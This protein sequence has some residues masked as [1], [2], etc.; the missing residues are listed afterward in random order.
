MNAVF[1]SLLGFIVL[2][3]G[4]AAWAAR[5]IRSESDFLVAGRSLGPWMAT[6]TVF[7]TWFGAETCIGAAGEAYAGGLA[8]VRVDPFGYAIG[9][10]LMGLLL[11]AALWR[12]QLLTL[13]DLFRQRWGGGVERLA[14]LIMIPTSLLWAAAQ[15]RALGQVM[16]MTGLEEVTLGIQVAALVVILYT[17]VGGLWADALSDLVQGLVLIAGLLGLAVMVWLLPEGAAPALPT[18]DRLRLQ[19]PEES[20]WQ[21]LE[22]WAVPIGG[23]LAAQELVSRV[24]AMRSPQLARRATVQAGLLYLLIGLIPVSLGLIAFE[25]LGPLDEPEQVLLHLAEARLPLLLFI[26]FVAALVSAILSTVNSALLVAG[27]L[28]AHNLVL[29]LRPDLGVSARLRLNRLAVAAFG[30]IAYLIALSSDS[31][32]ALVEQASALGSAGVLVLIVFALLP[33]RIGGPA[34]ASAALLSGVGVY[35][36]GSQAGWSAPYLSSL[37]AALL[38][39]LL[40]A[41]IEA[42]QEKGRPVGGPSNASPEI[43]T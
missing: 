13:A 4:F 1:L 35:V 15:I 34:A 30:G 24:L 25:Q 41:L 29:P 2:Q 42:R 10:L 5:R 14:A 17:V 27:G 33:R 12:R 11:G 39:Y 7:A 20:L 19:A 26:L 28:L 40:L 18:L 38:A 16:A 9:I 21:T 6:F 22:I 36:A 23:T 37:A 31:V 32:Y 43:S 8:A 3:L